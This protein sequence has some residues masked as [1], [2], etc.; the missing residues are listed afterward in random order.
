V[1]EKNLGGASSTPRPL[2]TVLGQ[3]CDREVPCTLSAV[4]SK[5]L[6]LPTEAGCETC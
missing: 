1:H 3:S 4:R 6:S 5:S 2:V